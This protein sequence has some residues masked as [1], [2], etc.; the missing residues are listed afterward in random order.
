MSSPSEIGRLNLKARSALVIDGDRSR[1]QQLVTELGRHLGLAEGVNSLHRADSVLNRCRFDCVVLDMD[2]GPGSPLDWAARLKRENGAVAVILSCREEDAR[3]AV[4]ALR[5][6]VAD[7]LVRPFEPASLVAAV[8]RIGSGKTDSPRATAV[9]RGDRGGSE[10]DAILVGDSAA[11]ADVRD[12]V[13]RIA[14]L[15]AA[16]LIEGERGTGKQEL[17]RLLHQKSGRRG[18]FVSVDC[19]VLGSRSLESELFGHVKGAF[20]GAHHVRDGLFVAARGGT[21]FLKEI[22]DVPPGPAAG[23]VRALEEGVI[24]PAG[25]DKDLRVDVR[26]VASTS[27]DLAELVRKRSFRDDLYYKLDV[28]R[29]RLPPL[30][31]R[32]EDMEALAKFF[33]D[34]LA[35]DLGMAP[36]PLNSVQ[37]DDLRGYSWPGNVRELEHVVEKILMLGEVPASG[38]VGSAT[39]VPRRSAGY[40]EDWTLDQVKDHHMRRVLAACGDNRSEAARRLGVSRKTL[41]RKLGPR[42]GH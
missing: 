38:L 26:V 27:A 1:R 23:L 37:L 36:M 31:E 42:E 14:T 20:T 39:D 40:P 32:A 41:E 15:P 5:L 29:L 19:S 3:Q 18:A 22:G 13:E 30:R 10:R 34:H 25:S 28:I 35:A 12:A 7:I 8:R 24:R 4:G 33:M 16:V 11:I 2:A 9:P 6:G 21:L 17:A